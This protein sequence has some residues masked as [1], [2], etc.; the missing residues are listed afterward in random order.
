M[1]WQ[2]PRA[3]DRPL[4]RGD[5]GTRVRHGG[6]LDHHGGAAQMSPPIGFARSGR[7]PLA[8]STAPGSHNGPATAT[9]HPLPEPVPPRPAAN[10]RLVRPLHFRSSLRRANPLPPVHTQRVIPGAPAPPAGCREDRRGER[11]GQATG[12]DSTVSRYGDTMSATTAPTTRR[13][14]PWQRAVPLTCRLAAT[15]RKSQPIGT[16]LKGRQQLAA[17]PAERSG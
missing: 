8:A 9:A 10:V 5:S 17:T 14:R 11:S 12:H 16:T 4:R 7:Q 13:R 1:R 3:A 6:R 2:T 15:R